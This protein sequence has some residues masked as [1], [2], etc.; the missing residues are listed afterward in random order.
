MISRI[1]LVP[2]GSVEQETLAHLNESLKETFNCICSIGAALAIPL[3]AF[4]PSRKQY[5]GQDMLARLQ[6]VESGYVLGVADLD[7]YAPGLNFIFGLAD[8]R[9]KRAVIALPRLRQSFYGGQD[10]RE[11]FLSRVAK[12]AVHELGHL[13]GLDHCQDRSCVMAFSNSLADTDYKK[14]EFCPRCARRI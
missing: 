14:K 8:Y 1:V 5:A 12:E 10:K 2:I 7:L 9:A 6:V 13:Y 11:L 4:N 3:A